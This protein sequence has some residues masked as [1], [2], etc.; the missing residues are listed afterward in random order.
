MKEVY[1]S[2]PL[3]LQVYITKIHVTVAQTYLDNNEGKRICWKI[4]LLNAAVYAAW[5]FKRF[6]PFM[7][8]RFMH[9]PLS[10][11]SYTLLTSMFR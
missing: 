10:G 7:N 1:Q 4:C 11:R 2:I 8:I 5:K 9:H 3:L 6:Q